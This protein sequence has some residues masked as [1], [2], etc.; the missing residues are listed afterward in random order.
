MSFPSDAARRAAFAKQSKA[1]T[2]K[3]GKAPLDPLRRIDPKGILKTPLA[4]DLARF[5]SVDLGGWLSQTQLGTDPLT[6]V[7]CAMSGSFLYPD[8]VEEL[9]TVMKEVTAWAEVAWVPN[10]EHLE[11]WFQNLDTEAGLADFAI[12]EASKS[13]RYIAPQNVERVVKGALHL[14]GREEPVKGEIEDMTRY[15]QRHH[16]PSFRDRQ[17]RDA[18]G[19]GR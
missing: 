9:A 10:Q 17:Q 2:P 15:V 8:S 6:A 12:R 14:L 16:V 5:D 1:G 11:A 18:D 3:A 7:G 4:R 13:L 19:E